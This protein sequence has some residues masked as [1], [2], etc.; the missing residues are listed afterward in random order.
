MIEATNP[1]R[2]K[3]ET[4][5]RQR[6][7]DEREGWLSELAGKRN[8][9]DCGSYD[10]M[11]AAEFWYVVFDTD[12]WKQFS[13]YAREDDANAL[14]TPCGACNISRQIPKGYVGLSH[15]EVREWLQGH[16]Q[17]TPVQVA[18]VPMTMRA[19]SRDAAEGPAIQ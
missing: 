16:R 17:A 6:Q 1:I 4:E 14:Y 15:Q 12:R 8:C 19:A 10:G 3:L 9:P 7:L 13:W 2:E 5:R 18:N 11:G